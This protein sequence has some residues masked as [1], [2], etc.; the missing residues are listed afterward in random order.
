MIAWEYEGYHSE[1]GTALVRRIRQVAES[2]N[3]NGWKVV[4][5]HKDQRNECKD[6]PF[7]INTEKNGIKR[8]SVKLDEL[9]EDYDKNVLIRKLETFYYI[10]FKGDRSYKWASKV[11]DHFDSFGI[12]PDYIISFYTPRVPLYLGN[13][14]SRKLG[15]PWIADIQDPLLG[16]IS[17]SAYQLSVK[18][19]KKVLS[20]ARAVVHVS[21]EWADIDGKIIGRK[22]ETIRHAI[23]DNTTHQMVEPPP[24]F[25]DNYKD[26]FNIFY[27]GSLSAK[28]QSLALL[29][30]TVQAAIEN[31]AKIHLLVA[32]NLNAY[33]LFKNE[34]GDEVVKH[35]GWLTPLQMKQYITHCN[36]TLVVP[37][38]KDRV[39]IPSKF[40]ELCIFPKPIW[41]IGNDL[42]AF[43]T[44]LDEW[45]HPKIGIDS[46]SYQLNALQNAMTGNY[47]KMFTIDKCNG[48]LLKANELFEE[49]I[50]LMLPLNN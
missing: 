20:T 40:Y 44:L 42:G 6:K 28:I 8:I 14:Y 10:T 38:S 36:C 18:W 15:V 43:T 30:Q 11:K 27:G 49:Y 45:K 4:V 37:W 32:G 29:R 19:T 17:K 33:T 12:K 3:N 46:Y 21:P 41:I 22:I 24:G 13:Y 35:L 34:F 25:I 48:H 5:I 16:G 9:I 31:G 39:G 26:S 47:N 1:R 2:F 50:K 7:V 23:P